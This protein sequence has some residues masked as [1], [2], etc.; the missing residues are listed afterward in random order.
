MCDR[1]IL[2]WYLRYHSPTHSW[3]AFIFIDTSCFELSKRNSQCYHKGNYFTNRPHWTISVV[4]SF[5][6]FQILN[7][8]VFS[9]MR[10]VQSSCA[11]LISVGT[12]LTRMCRVVATRDVR[13]NIYI[14]WWQLFYSCH[15]RVSKEINSASTSSRSLTSVSSKMWTNGPSTTF[16]CSIRSCSTINIKRWTCARGSAK[17]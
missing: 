6:V 16:W 3:T 11:T 4:N 2:N 1:L 7:R 12:L 5:C 8:Q 14:S 15:H 13:A 10:T 9:L 17:C